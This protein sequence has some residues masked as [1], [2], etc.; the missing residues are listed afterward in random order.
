MDEEEPKARLNRR[1]AIRKGAIVIGAAWTLPVIQSV[2]VPAFAGSGPPS[3]N[4][5][6]TCHCVDGN[7]GLVEHCLPNEPGNITCLEHCDDYCTALGGFLVNS[8]FLAC[9][10]PS[11]ATCAPVPD[12]TGCVCGD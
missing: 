2:T 12:G 6:C 7:G 9:P 11:P 1:D 4:N 8:T 10:D 3:T 5:C